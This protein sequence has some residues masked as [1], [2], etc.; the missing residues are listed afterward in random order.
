MSNE[1]F[2]VKFGLAVGDTAATID[3]TTGN[4]VTNGS[5]TLNGSS[6]GSVTMTAGTTPAAQTYTLP[7]AYPAS[8]GYVLASTT[9][10]QLSWTAA[11]GAGVT[12]ITGTTNQ[13]IASASTGAVTLSTPQDIATTSNPTFASALLNNI[14]V[15]A[16]PNYIS[17]TSGT[18]Y[19]TSSGGISTGNV[20]ID[21][22][23]TALTNL[24]AGHSFNNTITSIT[25]IADPVNV[26]NISSSAD[27]VTPAVGFGPSIQAT[28]KVANGDFVK[29]GAISWVATDMT[30][31]AENFTLELGTTKNGADY[32]Y[33]TYIDSDGNLSTDG[34][35]TI[36]YDQTVAN[37]VL[38]A[39]SGSTLGSLTWDGTTWTSNDGLKATG[40]L[41][42]NY[43]TLPNATGTSGQVLTSN[44]GSAPT[45]STAAVGDVVGPSSATNNA[46]VRFDSTTGKL[47]KNSTVTIADTTGNIVTNG[48]I[49]VQGG[50]ISNTTGAMILQPNSGAGLTT[51]FT[52]GGNL[53]N[54]RNYVK[55]DVRQSAA[56]S[57]GDIWGFGQTGTSN[58]YRGVSVSN[59]GNSTTVDSKRSGVVLRTYGLRNT[60]YGEYARGSNPS[61]PLAPTAGTIL[62]EF[63]AG[64]YFGGNTTTAGFL[65]FTSTA[66]TISGTTLT[67]GTLTSGT[68]AVGQ[69]L[70]GGGTF[71]G[72]YIT[73]NISGSGSGSTWTVSYSQSIGPAAI[74]GGGDGWTTS[75]N[76]GVTGRF[77]WNTTEAWSATNTGTGFA[78]IATPTGAWAGTTTN[79]MT[80]TSQGT[81][82]SGDNPT[83]YSLPAPFGTGVAQLDI[84]EAQSTF[85]NNLVVQ[86]SNVSDSYIVSNQTSSFASTGS[87]ISGTTLT[88]GTLTSGT[89]AVGQE[90]RGTPSVV[91]IGKQV[92]PKTYI[93]ANISGSGSGSTWTVSVS[94]TVSSTPINGY[95]R[96]MIVDNAKATFNV[97]V[98]I[99]GSTS[100]SVSLAA[101]A[102][103]GSQ[104]YT[105]PTAYPAADNYRLVSTTAGVMSWQPAASSELATASVTEGA[106]YTPAATISP[107]IDLTINA[108]SGTT[109]IDVTNLTASSTNGQQHYIMCHNLTGSSTTVHVINSRISANVLISHAVPNTQ[110]K[111][112][113][114]LITIVGN[115]AAGTALSDI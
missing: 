113:L 57:A 54:S 28:S 88:I 26:I 93:T 12:S 95:T 18:L 58:P 64:G 38:K 106:T 65:S 63:S 84:F 17:T 107:Y 11:A 31:N 70:A 30:A 61:V 77:Q 51:L 27:G 29:V 76:T 34:D 2:K 101:P 3:G 39:Y 67:I 25:K 87:S 62:S 79:L 45:W 98:Q 53:Y 82:I 91:T 108:G 40:S 50:T 100:G 9:G 37:G 68:V 10:G 96:N 22:R 102:V 73:A 47:I 35:I 99:N 109:T 114:F 33:K 41:S 111:R 59:W 42:N 112:T 115:Y 14:Y 71:G 86:G 8:S 81:A 78:V 32:D 16:S 46:V 36:N 55:G 75:T 56:Q 23:L 49:D 43:F 6:S 105:L 1:K 104:S 89:I 60:F 44:G 5:L 4:I 52:N 83:Y 80:I 21:G 97:P 15:G 7:T 103:A 48:T 92:S 19:L 110:E 13:I 20:G 72:T 94:Q 69:F 74:T 85:S 90:V 66:S 24:T